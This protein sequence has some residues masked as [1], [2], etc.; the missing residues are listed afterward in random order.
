MATPTRAWMLSA[1]RSKLGSRKK[2]RPSFY[3]YDSDALVS[4]PSDEVDK[5]CEGTVV[6]IQDDRTVAPSARSYDARVV[7]VA[8]AVSPRGGWC[9]AASLAGDLAMVKV[10]GSVAVQIIGRV[11]VRVCGVGGPINVGDLLVASDRPGVAMRASNPYRALGA[12][13]GKALQRFGNR[14]RDDEATI[15]VL[16]RL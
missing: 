1:S 4:F 14:T 16:I 10:N 12:V 13:V 8:V 5:I 9:D 3:W 15:D 6:S 11:P 2:K 7:G